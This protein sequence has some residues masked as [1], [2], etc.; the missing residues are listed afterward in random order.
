MSLCILLHALTSI[1]NEQNCCK[2]YVKVQIKVQINDLQLCIHLFVPANALYIK[3][4][5]KIGLRYLVLQILIPDSFKQVIFVY[6]NEAF[7][8]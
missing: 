6:W 1:K 2:R 5:C 4:K 7:R 8:Y 3:Y